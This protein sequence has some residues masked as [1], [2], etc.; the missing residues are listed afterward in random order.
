[1]IQSLGILKS[2]VIGL[3]FITMALT[4]SSYLWFLV[5][6]FFVP[7]LSSSGI[8]AAFLK[9]YEHRM[10]FGM[11]NVAVTWFLVIFAFTCFLLFFSIMFIVQVENVFRLN[12]KM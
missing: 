1:V 3:A 4:F 6:W 2:I 8:L 7:M 5:R 10:Q 9:F 11:E 12:V